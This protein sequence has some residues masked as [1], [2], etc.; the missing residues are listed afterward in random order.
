MDEPC[1]ASRRYR[2]AAMAIITV[3]PNRRRWTRLTISPM[4]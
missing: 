3:D 1:S 4:R 2:D